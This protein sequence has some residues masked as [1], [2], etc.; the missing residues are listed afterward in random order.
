MSNSTVFFVGALILTPICL[1]ISSRIYK[2][3]IVFIIT[4]TI[5]SISA[6]TAVIA[7]LAGER[8]YI[9]LFWGGPIVTAAMFVSFWIIHKSISRPIKTTATILEAMADGRFEK[10]A[11]EKY[12]KKRD[13]IGILL[14]SLNT[15]VGKLGE[16]VG[17]INTV[18]DGLAA[19]SSQMSS[20]ASEL[21]SGAS[22]Q[23]SSV[24]EVS[25]SLE[26]MTSVVQQNVENTDKTEKTAMKAAHDADESGKLVVESIEAI[27][28][29]AA[30]V[31]FIEEIARQTNLLALNA[32]IE[33]ARA[34]ES[35]KGFAVVASEVRRLAERSQS[36]A[37]E[38]KELSS[39]TTN[40]TNKVGETLQKLI[41]DIRKTAE[42]VQKV[43]SSSQEQARGIEQINSAVV[44]LNQVVQNNTAM[45]EHSASLAEELS[46]QAG[47]LEEAASWFRFSGDG[48]RQIGNISGH[49]TPALEG[50][51][52]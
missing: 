26:E 16:I 45:A 42:M 2:K 34:G 13:E 39:K 10:V 36:A 30:K 29:I 50:P 23:A 44:Q 6:L 35:G 11:N 51:E 20:A 28:E 14:Q 3:S 52:T 46:G 1:F 21:S 25:S 33:A 27:N 15:T 9:H 12:L 19:G 47:S 37:G 22:E 32:A 43:N 38:I 8:G 41:P 48:I 17:S 24:E 5:I 40:L 49:S 18:A 4:S 7:F 31:L